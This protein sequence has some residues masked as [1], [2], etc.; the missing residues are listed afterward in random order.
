MIPLTAGV[1]VMPP[2]PEQAGGK[3]TVAQTIDVASAEMATVPPPALNWVV[4]VTLCRLAAAER[5]GCP[6]HPFW[7]PWVVLVA[8]SSGTCTWVHVLPLGVGGQSTGDPPP[9]GV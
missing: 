3:S 1:H 2:S 6:V 7:A 8:R 4:G 9:D 5:V